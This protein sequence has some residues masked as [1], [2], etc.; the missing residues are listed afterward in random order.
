MRVLIEIDGKAFIDID[1]VVAE[2]QA[3]Q[4]NYLRPVAP[5][6]SSV[7]SMLFEPDGT[8]SITID[9]RDVLAGSDD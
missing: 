1:H 2:V 7:S 9:Y 4:H 3:D 8:H 6:S 5:T